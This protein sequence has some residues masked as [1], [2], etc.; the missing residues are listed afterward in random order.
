MGGYGGREPKSISM[1]LIHISS[2]CVYSGSSLK[3]PK[4]RAVNLTKNVSKK[5]TNEETTVVSSSLPHPLN[6]TGK[7]FDCACALLSRHFDR[8]RD[9]VLTRAQAEGVC[10]MITWFADID[11]QVQVVE[12]CKRH[13]GLCY[14][15]VGINPDNIH[16]TNKKMQGGWISTLTDLAVRP[17][18]VAIATGLN[19]SRQVATH[20]AQESLLRSCCALAASAKLPLVL[21][22]GNGSSSSDDHCDASADSL[23]RSLEILAEEGW[24]GGEPQGAIV[25]YDALS[26]CGGDVD[27]VRMVVGGGIF[28]MVSAAMLTGEGD[29]VDRTQKCLRVIPAELLLA[30]S[31]SPWKTPQNIEDA[32]LRTLRNEPCNMD[33]VVA[34]ISAARSTEGGAETGDGEDMAVVLK[35]NALRVFNISDGTEESTTTDNSLGQEEEG[36]LVAAVDTFELKMAAIAIGRG[37]GTSAKSDEGEFLQPT[38]SPAEDLTADEY[39]ASADDGDA[40]HAYYCGKC[41]QP[42][43]RRECVLRHPLPAPTGDG[44]KSVFRVGHEQCEASLFLTL[45]AIEALGTLQAQGTES[46]LCAECGANLGRV[47][48]L[49]TLCSCGAQVD[50]PVVALIPSKV[51]YSDTK[52][53]AA[54]R[55]GIEGRG[56]VDKKHNRRAHKTVAHQGRRHRKGRD[57]DI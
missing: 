19:L 27:K 38:T 1:S 37:D 14:A 21:H 46:V 45:A 6:R 57:D 40:D 52:G 16:H 55:D 23:Q 44:K 54:T 24:L 51:A 15:V 48:P 56:K 39:V 32:Y 41:R 12:S 2:Y 26:A 33:A 3:N 8:D 43:A 4:V 7:Y 47:F 10:G 53:D 42:L 30:C 34:A 11:K 5:S 49:G 36:A 50:G 17:E 22:I 25:L 18:C 20:F 31:D 29:E 13:E 28:C 9:R 35:S